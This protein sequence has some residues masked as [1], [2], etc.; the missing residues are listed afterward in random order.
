MAITGNGLI[1][2]GQGFRKIV[3]PVVLGDKIVIIL[4]GG[5]KNCG[6]GGAPGATDRPNRQT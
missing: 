6:N 2:L 3:A 5:V 4:R 1:V